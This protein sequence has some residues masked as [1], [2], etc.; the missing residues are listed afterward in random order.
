MKKNII[1][2]TLSILALTAVAQAQMPKPE[3]LDTLIQPYLDIQEALASDNFE[4]ANAAAKKYQRAFET[5]SEESQSPMLT[6]LKESID[7]LAASKDIKDARASF[8]DLSNAM[9]AATKHTGVN[10]DKPLYI[11]HCPMAFSNAGGSWIQ[12]QETVSNPY[13]G[14]MMLRCGSIQKQLSG[15]QG[16]S[17]DPHAHHGH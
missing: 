5:G 17:N 14:S 11:A 2:I 12:D 15:T 13:Y 4:E 6:N 8:L 7:N 16:A 10:H 3:F 9:L 1:I